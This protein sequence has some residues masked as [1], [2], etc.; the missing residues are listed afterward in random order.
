MSVEGF[1]RQ[2]VQR[3]NHN[4]RALGIDTEPKHPEYHHHPDCPEGERCWCSQAWVRLP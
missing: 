1:R 3:M 2:R 4:L